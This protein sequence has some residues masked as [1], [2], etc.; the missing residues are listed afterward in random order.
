MVVVPWRQRAAGARMM[1]KTSLKNIPFP[2]HF[3]K[4]SFRNPESD[5]I[6]PYGFA[7]KME[8]VAVF[9]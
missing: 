9:I 4:P 6:D 2:A 1:E 3:V 8:T 5:Q 7:E